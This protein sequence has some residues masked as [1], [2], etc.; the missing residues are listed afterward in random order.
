MGATIFPAG[1]TVIVTGWSLPS[2]EQG[3]ATLEG[4]LAIGRE[5]D[6]FPAMRS[7]L[8]WRL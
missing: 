3:L 4:A 2:F 1:G 8:A 7:R 6:A 5:A